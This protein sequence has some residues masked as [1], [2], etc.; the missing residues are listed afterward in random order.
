MLILK[1][2]WMGHKDIKEHG[3]VKCWVV[4]R[5]WV[6]RVPANALLPGQ[7][8]LLW[9]NTWILASCLQRKPGL[10]PQ[11]LAYVCALA[12]GRVLRKWILAG[13]A[14]VSS[15]RC[16]HLAW[17]M[18]QARILPPS[19]GPCCHGWRSPYGKLKLEPP[20]WVTTTIG[21]F[22]LPS[23]LRVARTA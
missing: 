4:H 21:D 11:M 23:V 13:I 14:H 15:T 18:L 3:H 5:P 9:V 7:V 6:A 1:T 17:G 10:S 20:W 22:A 8:P 16:P 2:R 19:Q 12:W